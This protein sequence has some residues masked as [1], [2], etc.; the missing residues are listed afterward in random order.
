MYDHKPVHGAGLGL[1]RTHLG[2]LLDQ[3]PPQ[4]DFMEICPEGWIGVGGRLGAA[5][6][7]IARR[8]PLAAH[9]LLGNFGGPDPLDLEYLQ[10][11]KHFLGGHAIALFSDH[12]TYC[13]DGGLLYEL[14][15]VPF[16]RESARHMAARIRQ[17]QDVLERPVAVENASYYLAPGQAMAEIDFLCEVLERADCGLLLDINNVYVNSVNHGYDARE[18]LQALPGERICYAHIAGHLRVNEGLA[19]DTHGAAVCEPVWELLDAAYACFG[20]FPTLLERDENIPSLA[21]CL[22]EVDR[23]AELQRRHGA[24]AEAAP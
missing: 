4:I 2:P 22:E 14:L 8:V 12:M 7:S 18:F 15:P 11:L 21:Q 9:G 3:I 19:V 16:T 24:A 10:E 20:V 1:R 17:V 6:E 5:L 23:I 13:G